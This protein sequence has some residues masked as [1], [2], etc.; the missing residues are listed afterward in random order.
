MS[1]M[2]ASLPA[3]AQTVPPPTAGQMLRAAREAQGLHLA[4]LSVKL[5]IGV[6]QLEALEADRYEAFKGVA[7]VRALALSVCRQ[8]RL[9]PT[10]VMAALPKWDVPKSQA[11]VAAGKRQDPVRSVV[12]APRKQGLSRQVLLLALLM[13]LGAAVLIWWPNTPAPEPDRTDVSATPAPTEEV[14]GQAQNPEQTP[15]ET[16]P[17]ASATAPP[18]PVAVA[19]ASVAPRAVDPAAAPAPSP[20]VLHLKADAWVEIRGNRGQMAIKRMVKADEVLNLDLAGPL[21]VYVGRADVAE[22]RWHGQLV[23]LK[24]FTQNNEARLQLQP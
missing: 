4:V 16:T 12:R 5:K 6:G 14:M 15:A 11:N 19:S 17:A 23:D 2:D 7:F 24:P 8:L 9:D 13:V 20:L 18:V 3:D 21:F 10:P 1:L 22:L